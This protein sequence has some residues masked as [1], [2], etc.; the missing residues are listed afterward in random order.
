MRWSLLF[1]AMN[2]QPIGIFDSGLGGLSVWSE[3]QHLL[4]NEEYVY[5]G[6][7]IFCPYGEKKQMDI[8]DRT[9]K[10][11]SELMKS[12]CKLIVIACNTAT[13]AAIEHLREHYDI[14][15]VG[16]EPAIK[17][18]AIATKTGKVG[19]L[20]T[21][22]TFNGELFKN[23]TEKYAKN[24]ETISQP[25][26]GLVELV[27]IG[28]QY[29]MDAKYLLHQYVSPMLEANVDHIVLGCTHYPFFM[30]LL[31]ELI[32]KNVEIINPAPA[33][34]QRTMQLL[35]E[36]DL[37]NQ[38]SKTGVTQFSTSGNPKN[39]EAFITSN[40]NFETSAKQIFL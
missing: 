14:P 31:S 37:L 25:G 2:N 15:F 29:S 12:S 11:V 32:P 34:A 4:P 24:I 17:P 1:K 40:F 5:F 27:E 21:E 38:A 6:D 33:I 13:A 7:S 9:S 26:Y 23:T 22:G 30:K 35:K 28:Q 16:M 19:I 8:K 20:A 36:K 18:A 3:L 39:M 10:I